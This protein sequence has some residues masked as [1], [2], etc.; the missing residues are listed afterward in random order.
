MT[1]NELRAACAYKPPKALAAYRE[2]W[3]AI[4]ADTPAQLL[5]PVRTVTMGMLYHDVPPDEGLRVSVEYA[6]LLRIDQMRARPH[7]A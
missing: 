1:F 2:G 7:I 4:Y 5:E 3:A 6:R